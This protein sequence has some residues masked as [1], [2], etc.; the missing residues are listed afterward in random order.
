VTRRL[1]SVLYLPASN[2]RA[3]AKARTVPCDAVVLDLEDAVAPEAKVA[4]RDAAVAAVREGGWG[5]RVLVVRVNALDTEWGEGDA[6]ALA[7][8]RPDAVLVPKVAGA[9]TLGAVRALAGEVA[10]WAM[11]ETAAGVVALGD[12]VR[13]PGLEALVAGTNDLA[14]DLRCRPGADRAS[15][16]PALGQVVLH[17]RAA[18]LFALD[19]V[20]NAIDD[21]GR[22]EAECRQGLAWGFDGK[23]LIHPAQV[24][25]AN[26]VWTPDY[27][28]IAAA[29]AM[30]AA[31]ALPEHAGRG[32]IRLDGRMVE[33]LHLDEARRTLALAGR[34]HG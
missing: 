28:E 27:A 31:F 32:A 18:G 11:V 26:R 17:A 16:M 23:T 22:L 30:V 20:L 5:D 1:R 4:A 7:G 10:L 34:E 12:T 2:A 21:P 29:E 19:G 33:R 13:A 9:E 3:I 8:A 24:E 6:R 25:V 15:L 14:L